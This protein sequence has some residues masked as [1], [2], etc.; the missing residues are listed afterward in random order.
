[1]KASSGL[2]DASSDSSATSLLIPVLIRWTR[3]IERLHETR[4]QAQCDHVFV[5]ELL[6]PTGKA[7]E[8]GIGARLLG[9]VSEQERALVIPMKLLQQTWL[10][11]GAAAVFNASRRMAVARVRQGSAAVPRTRRDYRAIA[12]DSWSSRHSWS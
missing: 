5:P 12:G 8:I 1:L 9:D 10:L 11:G 4:R 2:G 7:Q 6:A 3:L